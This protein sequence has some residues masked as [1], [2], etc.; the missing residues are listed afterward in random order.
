[1]RVAFPSASSARLSVSLPPNMF[2][3]DRGITS[4]IKSIRNT[5]KG[6]KAVRKVNGSQ[7]NSRA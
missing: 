5:Y 3:A 6:E 7:V 1:M 4:T 2:G